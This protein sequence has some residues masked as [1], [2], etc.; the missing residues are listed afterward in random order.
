MI[1]HSRSG[2]YRKVLRFPK[3]ATQLE[4]RLFQ[5][6]LPKKLQKMQK[7]KIDKIAEVFA[8]KIKKS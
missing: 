1:S 6:G 3:K 7:V 2:I 5:P 4:G 8:R